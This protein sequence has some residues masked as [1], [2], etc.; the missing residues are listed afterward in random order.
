MD[1]HLGQIHSC[2]NCKIFAYKNFYGSIKEYN[3]LWNK[4]IIFKEW[5]LDEIVKD[6]KNKSIVRRFRDCAEEWVGEFVN[7]DSYSYI[8]RGR[9]GTIRLPSK[10]QLEDNYY[11]VLLDAKIDS[12]AF[13]IKG[14]SL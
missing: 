4:E 11:M 8:I 13:S 7:N 12:E 3:R 6:V 9:L 10:S 14:K 1:I 2:P 5:M